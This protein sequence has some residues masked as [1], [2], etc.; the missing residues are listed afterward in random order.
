MLVLGI[1]GSPRPRGNTDLL[2]DAF[3]EGAS[4]SHPE[5]R[6]LYV[7][8][9]RIHGCIECGKCDET[10]VC[11]QQ[12]DMAAVYPL[13][14][15]ASRIVI[16]SPIFFYGVT[17]Q[18]KLLIDRSQALY[19]KREIARRQGGDASPDP[20]RRGF[21]LSAGATGGKRMF[22]CAI[23]TAKYFFDALGMT[24]AGELCYPR[25][26][27]KGDIRQHPTALD[28]CVR[29]GKSFTGG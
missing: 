18:L 15:A 17:A 29:T 3:L 26:E 6:R 16:A 1:Y 4:S 21:L 22:E 11:V 24:Y 28:D 9:M 12:D 13:L 27:H 14:E 2:L 8:N 10:G 5:V 25:I 23:L 7:R 20:A 19:M